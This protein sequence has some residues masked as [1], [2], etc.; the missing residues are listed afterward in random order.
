MQH[1][2]HT[3][4]WAH[5]DRVGSSAPSTGVIRLIDCGALATQA[6]RVLHKHYM[7]LEES[8]LKVSGLALG[9]SRCPEDRLGWM[10]RPC[11]RR[12]GSAGNR[13]Q[14]EC[15]MHQQLQRHMQLWP[16]TQ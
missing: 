15:W 4:V 6:C 11:L 13:A 12:S 3:H 9:H 1:R 5:C 14:Y 8:G 16:H 2:A 10:A 7:L